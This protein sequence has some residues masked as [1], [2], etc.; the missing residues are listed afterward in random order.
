MLALILKIMLW[1]RR[2]RLKAEFDYD[3]HGLTKFLERH[4]LTIANDQVVCSSCKGNCGS[5]NLERT[6]ENA[7]VM[8]EELK[9]SHHEYFNEHVEGRNN[10]DTN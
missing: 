2:R 3:I 6:L 7:N 10:V 8:Y 1:F 5:C 9:A 4:V